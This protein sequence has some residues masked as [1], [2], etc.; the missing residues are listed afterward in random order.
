ML[1]SI[2]VSGI[3]SCAFM[4]IMSLVFGIIDLGIVFGK[5]NPKKKL[6]SFAKSA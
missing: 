1:L 6:K 4:F 2:A 3:V 5:K